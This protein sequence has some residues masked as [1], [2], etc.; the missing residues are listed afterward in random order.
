MKGGH[1]LGRPKLGH[2]IGS[3][4]TR[5]RGR[6]WRCR[7]TGGTGQ[8][9]L[10]RSGI[11]PLIRGK[12]SEFAR[13]FK[14]ARSRDGANTMLVEGVRG[15]GIL[16][17]TGANSAWGS[18]LDTAAL[19]FSSYEVD[20]YPASPMMK[21]TP[22][23]PCRRRGRLTFAPIG[24]RCFLVSTRQSGSEPD[25][26]GNTRPAIKRRF[27]SCHARHCQPFPVA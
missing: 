7:P 24:A 18:A 12:F 10:A 11:D 27:S 21:A 22:V 20:A 4:S 1:R 3:R 14:A 25:S 16:I 6:C 5:H 8:R 19:I 26:S 9:K 17:M 2:W 15:A 23:Q 13:T